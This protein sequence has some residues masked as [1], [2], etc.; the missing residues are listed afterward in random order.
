MARFRAWYSAGSGLRDAAASC[1]AWK[2]LSAAGSIMASGL[3]V[4]PGKVAE[5]NRSGDVVSVAKADQQDFAEREG[6][7]V[8]RF[9]DPVGMAFCFIATLVAQ[10][11]LSL[12]KVLA[13]S[14]RDYDARVGPPY[15]DSNSFL[16]A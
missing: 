1:A 5:G 13:W 6:S 16:F 8:D 4:V 15:L 3:D 11:V 10:H 7:S 2:V 14:C 12:E 9:G